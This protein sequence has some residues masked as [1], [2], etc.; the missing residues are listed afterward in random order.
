M[1][2]LLGKLILPQRDQAQKWG[3]QSRGTIHASWRDKMIAAVRRIIPVFCRLAAVFMPGTFLA[4]I[5]LQTGLVKQVLR[6]VEPILKL[7][8]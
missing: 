5:L 7:H 8:G 1:G 2:L 4:S 6:E 3:G